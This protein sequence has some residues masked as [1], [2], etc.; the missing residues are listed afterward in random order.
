MDTLVISI[1]ILTI[2]AINNVGAATDYCKLCTNHIA[3]NNTGK[4]AS[5]CPTDAAIVKLT[6]AD[7]NL[8]VIVHNQLRNKLAGGLVQ[9][10]KSA[11]NMSLVVSIDKNL[12]NFKIF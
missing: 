10:F 8:F 7:I 4:F 1:I 6:Q 3:C 12:S 2:S 9:G 11:T 5:T